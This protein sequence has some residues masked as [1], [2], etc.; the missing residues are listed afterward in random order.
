MRIV[1]ATGNPGKR[2]EIER[3]LAGGAISIESPG[4]LPRWP[5]PEETGA[6]FAEN[7][8]IKAA[9]AFHAT[10]IPAL[11]DD[12]GIEV[13]ALGGAP[14]VMSARFGG[15]GLTDLERCELLLERMKDVPDGER[16]AR[17]RC[18]MVLHPAPAAEGTWITEGILEG[19]IARAPAGEG[20]FGYDPVFRVPEAGRT[21]AEMTR[22][23]KNA[24]SHRY[25]ALVEMK[26]LLAKCGERIE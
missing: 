12:S 2:A 14:G 20:G 9:A 23:E 7:A 11:A 4:G 3:I 16:T 1:L 13:D 18:V 26:A 6:T 10:G 24:L 22:E 17:F 25:R 15:E 5:E 8:M 19:V 21:A